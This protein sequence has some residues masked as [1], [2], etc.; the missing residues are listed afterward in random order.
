M[1]TTSILA[2]PGKKSKQSLVKRSHPGTLQARKQG[3]TVVSGRRQAFP[4]WGAAQ[5]PGSGSPAKQRSRTEPLHG[6]PLP[7]WRRQATALR[8][9]G[10][11]LSA[12]PQPPLLLSNHAIRPALSP[13]AAGF[14]RPQHRHQPSQRHPQSS[15]EPALVLT[16]ESDTT[17]P[18]RECPTPGSDGQRQ[19]HL[20][21]FIS[22][23][24]IA[25]F[26]PN[27]FFQ[28]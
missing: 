11:T 26:G 8:A 21:W 27:A 28:V 6:A 14:T 23:F 17:A 13:G 24:V 1:K 25:Q 16:P 5:P 10:K 9:T 3:G 22:G 20:C 19:K 2:S 18:A 15:S 12:S 7:T 4:A